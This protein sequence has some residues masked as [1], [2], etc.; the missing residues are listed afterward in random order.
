M[1]MRKRKKRKSKKRT[2]LV[3][4]KALQKTINLALKRKWKEK[5]EN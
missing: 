5:R 3:N 2:I 1:V 4:D